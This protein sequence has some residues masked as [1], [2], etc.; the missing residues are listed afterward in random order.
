MVSVKKLDAEQ[1]DNQA[2]VVVAEIAGMMNQFTDDSADAKFYLPQEIGETVMPIAASFTS[3]IYEPD[4]PSAL[5]YDLPVFGMF[6]LA[7]TYGF[8]VFLKE[9]SILTNSAPFKYETSKKKLKAERDKI[10]ELAEVHEMKSTDLSDKIFELF[11]LNM[12]DNYIREEFEVDG[13]MF[14][15]EKFFK[16]MATSLFWGYNYAR[17]VIKESV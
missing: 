1:I 16:Y 15:E 8:Q 12:H 6:Y 9:H 14:D 10:F 5:V 2:K 17:E 13:A 7:I 4:V 11:L 3:N